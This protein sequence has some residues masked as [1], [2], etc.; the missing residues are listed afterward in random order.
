MAKS[1]FGFFHLLFLS[2]VLVICFFVYKQYEK[3][4]NKKHVLSSIEEISKIKV[5]WEESATIAS[6]VPRVSLA[7]PV[8]KLQE[9]KKSVVVINASF[10]AKKVKG[11]LVDG[12][13][14]HIKSFIAFMQN[15]KSTFI[16]YAQAAKSKFSDYESSK[17][18]CIS[19][20]G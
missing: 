16:D 17:V 20:W 15:E 18:A 13:D 11:D 7:G 6:S 2:F 4:Q 3:N 12:M 9:I 1:K 10:C 19:E 14:L 5:D 8:S